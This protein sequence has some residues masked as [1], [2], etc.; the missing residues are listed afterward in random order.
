MECCS[1]QHIT[2]QSRMTNPRTRHWNSP[3]IGWQ[4]RLRR[5]VHLT[6]SKK[7]K[8]TWNITIPDVFLLSYLLLWTWWLEGYPLLA[9]PEHKNRKV[10]PRFST[11]KQCN[12]HLYY[13][14]S[15]Q[16]QTP[17]IKLQAES[18]DHTLGP[19]TAW[20]T[21]HCSFQIQSQNPASTLVFQLKNH[22][23]ISLPC[24]PKICW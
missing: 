24:T 21:N 20:N 8:G 13:K 10:L 18:G 23:H 12:L 11:R 2:P 3:G 5:H 7:N 9:S 19:A 14:T 15:S 16:S 17:A 22:F 4:E 1:L 6:K